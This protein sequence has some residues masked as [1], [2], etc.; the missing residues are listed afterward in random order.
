MTE[1]IAFRPPPGTWKALD[2]VA[3]LSDDQLDG[4][5]NDGY[6]CIFSYSRRDGEVL[7]NPIPGGEYG[8][9]VANGCNSLA[10]STSRRYLKRGFALSLVQFGAF[11][12][13]S[14]GTQMGRA[15][16]ASSRRLGFPGGHHHF[17]D[18]EGNGPQS[19]G[20][21]KVET[22]VEAY[23]GACMAGG[24]GAP[25]AGMYYNFTCM[26]ARQLYAL[27]GITCYWAAAGPV[28]FPPYPRGNSVEQRAPSTHHGVEIDRDT[29]RTDRF[30]E[31]PLLVGTPEIVATWYAQAIG[32][33]AG[34]PFLVV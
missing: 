20:P 6:K 17:C 23:S 3:V 5:S 32:V 1:L 34:S 13:A 16:A 27:R 9:A 10:I 2:T 11:G 33:L 26:D 28:P 31:G 21:A 12:S 30:G 18:V 8:D 7:D 14:Y 4:F 29:I 25:L 24:S 19:A 22:Y 15:A